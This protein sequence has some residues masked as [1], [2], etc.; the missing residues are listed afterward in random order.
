MAKQIAKESRKKKRGR[1]P[2]HPWAQWFKL[3][4][5]KDKACCLVK[6]EDYQCQSSSLVRQLRTEAN[7]KGLKVTASIFPAVPGTRRK[8][9]EPE[10]VVF[11]VV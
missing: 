8:K 11:D 2:S 4:K 5:R 9:A 10:C 6:G 1:K 7:R 3:A